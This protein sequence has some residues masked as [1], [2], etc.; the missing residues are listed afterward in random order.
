MDERAR[1]LAVCGGDDAGLASEGGARS[2][3]GLGFSSAFFSRNPFSATVVLQSVQEDLHAMS[4][5]SSRLYH[6]PW[7]QILHRITFGTISR[8]GWLVAAKRFAQRSPS[9]SRISVCYPTCWQFP[10]QRGQ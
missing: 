7:L 2:P 3:R 1:A 5:D 10:S 9:Y 4:R 6:P 8:A